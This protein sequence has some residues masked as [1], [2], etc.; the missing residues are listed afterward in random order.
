MAEEIVLVPYSQLSENR[1]YKNIES[2]EKRY[3]WFTKAL[4]DFK[5]RHLNI[6]PHDWGV[7]VFLVYSFCAET[8]C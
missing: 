4:A 8:S 3:F 7:L 6:F 5:K 1:E 2:V